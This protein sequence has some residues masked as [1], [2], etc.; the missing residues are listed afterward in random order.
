M[1]D[2]C[3]YSL[4]HNFLSLLIKLKSNYVIYIMRKQIE[5]TQFMRITRCTT[6]YALAK[7][8]LPLVII[9]AHK[10]QCNRPTL[11]IDTNL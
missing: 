4:C 8:D 3:D 9:I 2:V 11:H 7:S 5:D 1:R 10:L 6:R